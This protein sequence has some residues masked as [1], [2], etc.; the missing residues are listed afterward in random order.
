LDYH[1]NFG[2]DWFS[3]AETKVKMQ[4]MLATDNAVAILGLGVTGMSCARYFENCGRS[5]V[6][7]DENPAPQSVMNFERDFPQHMLSVGPLQENDLAT[8]NTIV[9]SPGIALDVPAIRRASVFG[10]NITGDISLFKDEVTAPVVAITGS[11]GKST[12]TALVGEMAQQAGRKVAVGGNI[13]KP[14]LDLLLDENDYDLYVVELSSYQL[15]RTAL[16][17]ADA[18]VVLNLSPDHLDRY[19]NMIAYHQAKHRIHRGCHY[20]VFNRADRLTQP[21]P[22]KDTQLVSFGLNAADLK[23]YGVDAGFEYLMYG[24]NKL[25]PISE[26][27]LQGK[28]NIEN[29]LAALALGTGIGLPMPAMLT[30]I[31]KFKGLSHRCQFVA[32]VDGVDYINDSKGTNVGATLAAIHGLATGN[33]D[34]VLIAGGVG[35]GADFKPLVVASD[36]LKAAVLIGKSADELEIVLSSKVLCIRADSMS[37]AVEQAAQIAVSGD[38][39]LLS[40]ACA[41]FD[42]FSSFEHRGQV[43]V[44]AINGLQAEALS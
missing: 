7:F 20:S 34:I 36:K 18:A 2:F 38:T 24:P 28:H 16:L 17:A 19:A 29:A 26:M 12:V 1:S 41:S 15:E 11:N 13:G 44:D 27:G 39:V 10:A 23:Q 42:M 8:F 4:Q 33:K 5:F 3:N 43:F 37:D 14:V 31:R 21:L 6:M 40:P 9:V 25:M 35:K 22:A 32:T 30:A